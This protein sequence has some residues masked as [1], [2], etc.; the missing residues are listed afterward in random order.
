MIYIGNPDIL[1]AVKKLNLADLCI[2]GEIGFLDI[3]PSENIFTLD[4]VPDVIVQF[5]TA[6]GEK[7]ERCLCA[8]LS[9][10]KLCNLKI[11]IKASNFDEFDQ[12]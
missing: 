5:D 11:I 8:R 2:V 12:K 7:C 10:K 6:N 9:P 4:D 3:K 1:S